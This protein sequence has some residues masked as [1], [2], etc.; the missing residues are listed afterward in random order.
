MPRSPHARPLA[1]DPAPVSRRICTASS[2]VEPEV[3]KQTLCT[4]LPGN[5][6]D[7]WLSPFQHMLREQRA[8][9]LAEGRESGRAEGEARGEARGSRTAFAT[10]LLQLLVQRFGKVPDAARSRIESADVQRLQGWFAKALDAKA[11]DE[12]LAD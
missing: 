8:E 12:A 3:L 11:I 10:A 4:V 1:P 2:K 6:H 5:N 7:E 9:G